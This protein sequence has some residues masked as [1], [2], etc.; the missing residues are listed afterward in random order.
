MNCPAVRRQADVREAA[1]GCSGCD[2]SICLFVTFE[3]EPPLPMLRIAISPLA[4]ARYTT[5]FE[6]VDEY[7]VC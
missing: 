4:K 1:V 2:A 5:L 3:L 6:L 7:S